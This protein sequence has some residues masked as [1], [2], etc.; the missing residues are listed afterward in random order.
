MCPS[1]RRV[2][3]LPTHRLSRPLTLRRVADVHPSCSP[4]DFKESGG[5]SSGAE[6][7]LTVCRDD[8]C[9]TMLWALTRP[10]PRCW[11]GARSPVA[12]VLWSVWRMARRFDGV[13]LL[14]GLASIPPLGDFPAP[15]ASRVPSDPLGGGRTLLTHVN[16]AGWCGPFARG[17]LNACRP[18][19]L[20]YTSDA[21]KPPQTQ[22][23]SLTGWQLV[24]PG[25]TPSGCQSH[26]TSVEPSLPST[27]PL[28]RPIRKPAAPPEGRRSCR[29]WV[30]A[31]ERRMVDTGGHQLCPTVDDPRRTS[32]TTA[33]DDPRA[34]A[35][36]GGRAQV[37]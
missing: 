26:R 16:T 8:G 23:L 31:G 21:L 25:T 1:E 12:W 17:P 19:P 5:E 10:S 13:T 37:V 35:A 11:R 6:R 30:G 28:G 4:A 36:D 33:G 2:R 14:S 18:P 15:G 32:T 7:R 22:T 29:R 34:G 3:S 20:G 24:P 27:L 9:A